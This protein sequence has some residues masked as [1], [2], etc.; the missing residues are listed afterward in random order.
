MTFM[1]ARS[2][3]ASTHPGG[4]NM[5][6][7]RAFIG[8]L[9]LGLA[10]GTGSA[11]ADGQGKSHTPLK[12]H[13]D[14]DHDDDDRDDGPESARQAVAEGRAAPLRELLAIV[15][16]HYPGEVVGVKLRARGESL[17]YRV[18]ILERGGRLIT[19]GIDAI[20]RRIVVPGD[21]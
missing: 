11:L 9:L 21:T 16:S 2:I 3:R 19:V 12:R 20:S 6:D 15:R 10:C 8:F 17:I 18:R 13:D 14:G 4:S 5:I 7:R 1:G